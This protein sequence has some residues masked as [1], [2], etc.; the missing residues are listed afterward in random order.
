[1]RGTNVAAGTY[2]QPRSCHAQPNHLYFF[3]VSQLRFI[4]NDAPTIARQ[5]YKR[6]WRDS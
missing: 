5:A 6:A 4:E 3:L 2:V 1:M